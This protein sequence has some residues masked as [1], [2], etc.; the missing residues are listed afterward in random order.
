MNRSAF[1]TLLLYLVATSTPGLLGM[2]P[3]SGAFIVYQ[4]VC[5]LVFMLLTLVSM[6]VYRRDGVF[7]GYNLRFLLLY[8]GLLSSSLVYVL[9]VAIQQ[10]ESFMS[11]AQFFLPIGLTATM[12]LGFSNVS[13]SINVLH[14]FLTYVV[15][16]LVGSSI[17][18][19]A[20]N[21]DTIASLASI[22]N[23]YLVDVKGFFFNR[24]VFG[25]M[26]AVGI[27]IAVYV[28]TQTKKNIFMVGSTLMAIS[29]VT[30][31]SRGA[32]VFL[33]VFLLMFFLQ[34]VRSKIKFLIGLA[35]FIVPV[36]L[37]I[38]GQ[39]FVQNNFIRAEVGSSGRSSLQEFGISRYGNEDSI[40][41]GGGQKSLVALH[42]AYGHD[43]YHNLYL[44]VLFTQGL[45]GF[46]ALVILLLFV[47]RNI[48]VVK[49]HDKKAGS[50]FIAL[51]VAYITYIFFEALPLFYGTPNSV[52]MT[53]LIVVLPV[54]LVNS[55]S[56]VDI[57]RERP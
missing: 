1:Y 52:L 10:D 32:F 42:E 8:I 36:S 44:E 21:F 48:L 55:F 6:F 11:M 20:M 27:A 22:E 13:F 15:M 19:I 31:M 16:F 40:L 46:A 5:F 30:A 26:M 50:F 28:W 45:V 3:G 35:V 2:S 57:K 47:Y 23:S 12:L 9:Y 41:F 56:R 18:N 53:Y 7:S 49:R 25:Y 54:A 39:P 34:T 4:A 24:N 29:L 51:F 38:I 33:G 43:S 37:F 17:Y 14:R